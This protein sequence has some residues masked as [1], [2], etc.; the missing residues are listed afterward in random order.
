MPREFNRTDRVGEQMLKELAM[1]VQRELNDPRLGM[2]T[3]NAVKVSRDLSYADVYVS[4]LNFDPESEEA[5][6]EEAVSVLDQ[7]K[8]FLRSEL[9]KRI[10]LR[11]MPQ[12]RF[13]YDTVLSEANRVDALIR[14][15]RSKDQD[16]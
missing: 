6:R 5:I 16:G 4:V 1:L 14:E 13:H 3:I 15:A 7:A 2:L 12:L 9:S 8:G 11:V 10:K